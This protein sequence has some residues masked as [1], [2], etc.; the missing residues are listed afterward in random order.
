[1]VPRAMEKIDDFRIIRE[2]GRGAFGVVYEAEE[3]PLGRHVALKLLHPHV[4]AMPELAVRFEA[5]A[6]AL[7][8]LSHPGIVKIH[9]FGTCA[10]TRYLALEFIEGKPLDVV[11]STQRL[12]PEQKISGLLAI[13]VALGHAHD[14][15]I[16]HRDLKPGNIFLRVDGRPVV[17]DFGLVKNLNPGVHPHTSTGST[18]GTPAY[19]SPEQCSGGKVTPATDVYSLGIVAFELVVGHVP[20]TGPSLLQ[21][22]S[23][24][25]THPAPLLRTQKPEAP[26]ALEDLV[27]RMLEKDPLKRPRDGNAVAAELAVI[28]ASLPPVASTKGPVAEAVQP[29]GKSVLI[30]TELSVVCFELVG[31]ARGTCQQM[32]P[33]RVAFLLESWY[34]LA[35]G[36][37]EH[38]GGVI[39]RFVGDR[40]TA[41]FGYPTASHDHACAAVRAA[42]RLQRELEAFNGRQNLDLKMRAG[43]AC[44]LALVGR[45]CGDV[46][47]T[48]VEG[49]ILGDMAALTKCK[50]TSLPLR[51]NHAA[52][53]RASGLGEFVEFHQE[54]VGR[55]WATDRL[56]LSP[57]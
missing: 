54:R 22:L 23:Q 8:L 5:E 2:L 37:T 12:S 13:A 53:R 33:A 56:D 31:F 27:A 43:I 39:D 55:A 49:T 3:V 1:M 9:R 34:R 16:V 29:S 32:E 36:A 4:A 15:G 42:G 19:M 47:P 17:G 44:G 30:E 21:M 52:Y 26:E 51:L 18:L 6:K 41:V 24:H 20:F 28:A 14:R 57:S 48:N 25:A 45:V 46:A 7:A 11:L 50:E 35:R 38:E 10:D 40:G